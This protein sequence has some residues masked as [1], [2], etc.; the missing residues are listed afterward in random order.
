MRFLK[1]AV[2]AMLVVWVSGI[3]KADST[4]D[5]TALS[6]AISP[7]LGS[8]DNVP[9]GGDSL[10]NVNGRP[11][12]SPGCG[13]LLGATGDDGSLDLTC[14]NNGSGLITS[15]TFEVLNT[16]TTGNGLTCESELTWIGWTGPTTPSQNANGVDT[17]TF[18]APAT[19]TFW[20]LL[21][22][23]LIPLG[24]GQA[25]DCDLDDFLL[26]IPSGC[27]V[28]VTTNTQPGQTPSLFVA[29]ANVGL[30]VNGANLPVLTPEPATLALLLIGFVAIGLRRRFQRGEAHVES[31]SA[32]AVS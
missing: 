16:D 7:Y 20:N 32:L 6:S 8:G 26:G 22:T 13:S 9:E 12:G 24:E 27:D 18:T 19:G 3:A 4:S 28:E 15:I 14:T 11:P 31:R 1:V 21:G 10:V 5:E 29:D 25:N 17:C 2:I 23:A 30:G